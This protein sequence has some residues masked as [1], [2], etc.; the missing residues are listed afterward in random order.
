[1]SIL[2]EFPPYNIHSFIIPFFF[3]SDKATIRSYIP[4]YQINCIRNNNHKMSSTLKHLHKYQLK[5]YALQSIADQA[6][7][8]LLTLVLRETSTNFPEG[9]DEEDNVEDLVGTMKSPK[10]LLAEVCKHFC[11]IFFTQQIVIV[12]LC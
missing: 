1:M 7:Q 11:L 10:R 12:S 4:Q 5:L 2:E 8:D 3:P 6:V 9:I